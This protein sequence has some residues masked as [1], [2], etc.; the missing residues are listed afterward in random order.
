LGE[1]LSTLGKIGC[2]LTIF[3]SVILI[4]HSPKDSEVN[5]LLD[6]ARKLTTTGKKILF[7]YLFEI[8][9]CFFF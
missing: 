1:K 2:L 5:T 9:H 3:G 4:I 6:F 7:K 8:E